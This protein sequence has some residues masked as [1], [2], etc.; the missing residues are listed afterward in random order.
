MKASLR[1]IHIELKTK[2]TKLY[3]IEFLRTEMTSEPQFLNRFII[4]GTRTETAL[5]HHFEDSFVWKT[6]WGVDNLYYKGFSSSITLEIITLPTPGK[7]VLVKTS[8]G[9]HIYFELVL[10]LVSQIFH[11]QSSR[12]YYK[13]I[14]VRELVKIS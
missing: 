11:L 2:K 12:K 5:Y 9:H 14:S 6:V 13:T 10:W 3:S 7:S 4:Y 8:H 1:S